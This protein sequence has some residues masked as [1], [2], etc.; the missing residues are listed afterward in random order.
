MNTY[1][2]NYLK[3]KDYEKIADESVKFIRDWFAEN[4]PD[5]KAV[6]GISGGK[7]S[8][9]VAAMCVKAL[10]RGRVIGVMMPNS[11]QPDIDVSKKLVDFLGI[12]NYEINIK[13]GYDGIVGE[14]TGKGI[15][16]S[17]QA[18]VNLGPRV[19]MSVLYAV[20]QCVNGRVSC[21]GNRSERYVG[22]FTKNGDGAGD[23]APL[24]NLTVHEVRLVGKYLGLPDEFTMKAPADGLTGLTDEDNLGFT[25][26]ALDTYILTGVCEDPDIRAKIDAKH[27]WNEFKLL[28]MP[29]FE[30]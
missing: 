6:I 20:A 9:V 27:A 8:S 5:S 11:V 18:K 17:K 16:L 26:E 15:G 29:V 13:N 19:R 2:E 12:E 4:G 7:D 22:Y 21:N 1:L 14:I 10:G 30:F 23:F 3:S 25:Y 24:A 28:P